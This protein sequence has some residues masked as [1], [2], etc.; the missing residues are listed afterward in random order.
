MLKSASQGEDL[1]SLH[2]SIVKKYSSYQMED[3]QMM[4]SQL[5]ILEEI[6]DKL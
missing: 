1:A 3:Y 4:Q 2:Q 6:K 5:E